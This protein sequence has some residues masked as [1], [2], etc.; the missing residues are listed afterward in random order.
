MYINGR[1]LI[2]PEIRDCIHKLEEERDE[3]KAEL[4]AAKEIAARTAESGKASPVDFLDL[5]NED[6]E[7]KKLLRSIRSFYGETES[8]V[9]LYEEQAVKMVGGADDDRT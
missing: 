6:A 4:R 9:D 8:W 1:W 3:L 7:L 2:E 5:L